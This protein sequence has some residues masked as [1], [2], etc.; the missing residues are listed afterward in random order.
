MAKKNYCFSSFLR[1]DLSG[2]TLDIWPLYLLLQNSTV[3][4]FPLPLYTQAVLQPFSK[5]TK[6]PYPFMKI[7]IQNK[8]WT[9]NSFCEFEN[10]YEKELLL[11]HAFVRYF[12]PSAGFEL[13]LFSE[14]PKG[15]GL[16]ASSSL[17]VNL[18]KCFTT[19]LDIKMT[20]MQSLTLCRDLE[21]SALHSLTGLQD[22]IIPLQT[23]SSNIFP[24]QVPFYQKHTTKNLPKNFPWINIIDLKPGQPNIKKIPFP[25]SILKN[26]LLLIHS[27]VEHHSA[28][29]NWHPIQQVLNSRFDF[30]PYTKKIWKSSKNTHNQKLS[31][32]EAC[33]DISLQMAAACVNKNF[34]QWPEL[35]KKELLLRQKL[36][37][38]YLP[39]KWVPKIQWLLQN[40]ALAVKFLGAG[41]GGCFL[42]WTH[43]K[44]ELSKKL[45]KKNIKVLCNLY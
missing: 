13:T 17:C 32:F 45:I 12:K 27:G 26:H 35:F 40:D 21:A 34:N 10:C 36:N 8:S 2:G 38:K 29:A 14:S 18:L 19:W 16:G 41:S 37:S 25:K 11:I 15:G 5:K 31:L 28:A 24:P 6:K 9:F 20:F 22:Y 30:W 23:V 39:K 7:N 44:K 3:V 1:A 4:Q 33:R 43:K 42:I